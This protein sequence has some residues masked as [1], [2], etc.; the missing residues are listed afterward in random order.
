M[1]EHIAISAQSPTETRFHPSDFMR[2][3]VE[4]LACFSFKKTVQLGFAGGR[5]SGPI[6]RV[7]GPNYAPYLNQ[8]PGTFVV[9]THG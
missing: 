5:L 1:R 9:E 8:P 6:T 2:E 4:F 3:L 7:D